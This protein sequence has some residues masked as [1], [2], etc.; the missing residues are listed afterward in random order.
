MIHGTTATALALPTIPT[1][2]TP[3]A[4]PLQSPR[5]SA[6]VVNAAEN[7]SLTVWTRDGHPQGGDGGVPA[8]TTSHRTTLYLLGTVHVSHQS[9]RTAEQLVWD[10]APDAVW[11]E[12]SVPQRA[13]TGRPVRSRV[14]LAA[15]HDDDDHNRSSVSTTT[16]TT[17]DGDENAA[18]RDG[19]GDREEEDGVLAYLDALHLQYPPGTD[20]SGVVGGEVVLAVRTALR[21]GAHVLLGDRDLGQT[22]ERIATALSALTPA[23]VQRAHRAVQQRLLA[24][25]YQKWSAMH[26]RQPRQ[27]SDSS[28]HPMGGDEQEGANDVV[29]TPTTATTSTASV[30]QSLRALQEAAL[31]DRTIVRQLIHEARGVAPTLV[32]TERDECMVH[33]LD[34][35]SQTYACIVAVVGMAHLDGI[36]QRLEARG[37]KRIAGS[38]Q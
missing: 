28:S 23:D 18:V 17:T 11:V 27:L 19:G 15:P 20:D 32:E 1:T 36:E 2:T 9:A 29:L 16:I 22:C 26:N 7:A 4:S 21:M 35:F 8:D 30:L 3:A 38:I 12:L 34:S 31:L 10:V 37:W 25:T 24:A 6:A 5:F 13:A 33:G 14:P